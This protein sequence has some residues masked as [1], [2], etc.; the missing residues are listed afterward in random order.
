MSTI[1]KNIKTGKEFTQP[2]PKNNEIPFTGGVMITE[3]DQA[4]IIIYA[5]KKFREMTGYT[6]EELIGSPHS[7]NRHPDMPKIAFKELWETIKKGE[8]WQGYVKNLCKDGSFYLV[9]VWVKA[10]F[11]ES[12]K[13]VGYIAGRKIPNEEHMQRALAQ[14]KTLKEKENN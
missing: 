11:D 3:T 13:I 14:Y 10:K 4:G 7:I 8:Y 2:K 6:N 12:K 9:E 5:N 1:I